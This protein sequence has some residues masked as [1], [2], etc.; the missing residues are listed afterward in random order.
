MAYVATC[1]GVRFCMPTTLES[2]QAIVDSNKASRK[3]KAAKGG[4]KDSSDNYTHAA[5]QDWRVVEV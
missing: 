2:A 3:K 5:K 1:N 4:N